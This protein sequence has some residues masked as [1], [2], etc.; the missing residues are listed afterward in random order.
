M[1]KTIRLYG[2]RSEHLA[3]ELHCPRR[4]T[5]K[6]LVIQLYGAPR[7]YEQHVCFSGNVD[8][9]PTMDYYWDVPDDQWVRTT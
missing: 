3:I 8:E 9:G 5:A 7:I 1:E 4:G 6:Y 2:F